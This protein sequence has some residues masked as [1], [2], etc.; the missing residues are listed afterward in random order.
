MFWSCAVRANKPP[1]VQRG[2]QSAVAF[3][4]NVGR[5][6]PGTTAG[7]PRF[8]NCNATSD[9]GQPHGSL[10]PRS[11]SSSVGRTPMLYMPVSK[12]AAPAGRDWPSASSPNRGL[13][14]S[15][16]NALPA[17]AVD[18]RFEL[19]ARDQARHAHRPARE[20]RAGRGELGHEVLHRQAAGV[21]PAVRT[22]QAA[23]MAVAAA[24]ILEIRI[25]AAEVGAEEDVHAAQAVVSRIGRRPRA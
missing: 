8:F 15:R 25:A 11:A 6:V 10:P 23:G 19:E 13:M 21:E 24:R 18:Q 20:L 3:G 12:N 22:H 16:R 1:V 14:K 2:E 9:S 4:S 5:R 17:L 7:P